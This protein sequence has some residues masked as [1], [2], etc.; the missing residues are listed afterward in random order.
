MTGT[1]NSN[2]LGNPSSFLDAVR[3][4]SET[5]DSRAEADPSSSYTA[6]LLA[7]G[8][9]NVAQKVSEEGSELAIAIVSEG[10]R[11]VASEAAD[12]IY[13]LLVGLRARGVALEHVATIL[14]AREGQSGL[15]EK[16]GRENS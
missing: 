4:L 3:I 7:K 9:K 11:E 1:T 10:E 8:H 2:S 6:S 5:I 16:A 13:H 12:L 14:K 15:E